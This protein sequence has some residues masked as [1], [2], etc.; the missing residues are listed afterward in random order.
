MIDGPFAKRLNRMEKLLDQFSRL[1]TAPLPLGE[2]LRQAVMIDAGGDGIDATL[3]R[4][5]S[6][7][8]QHR[9]P[10]VIREAILILAMF[11]KPL[12]GWVAQA[13]F[14]LIDKRTSTREKLQRDQMMKHTLRWLAVK[15]RRAAGDTLEASYA[16]AST[17]LA[18]TEASG[19]EETMRSSYKWVERELKAGRG[20][21]IRVWVEAIQASGLSVVEHPDMFSAT[22]VK[23][24]RKGN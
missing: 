3:A 22:T 11:P 12:P 17:A 20:A 7:W 6:V 16:A 24:V 23:R 13:A 15:E 8:R 19:H 18:Q 5:E 9:N 14:E 10:R 2:V 4:R 1:P 21:Q